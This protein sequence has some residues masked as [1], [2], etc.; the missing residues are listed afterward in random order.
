[1]WTNFQNNLAIF[2]KQIIEIFFFFWNICTKLYWPNQ[3]A[4][5]VESNNYVLK[6]LSVNFNENLKN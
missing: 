6:A 1:M 4:R 3:N 2:L 5:N